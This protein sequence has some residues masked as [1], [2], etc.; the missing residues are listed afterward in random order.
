MLALSLVSRGNS[1][2]KSFR[3]LCGASICALAIGAAVPVFA[4]Q[5]P[6]AAAAAPAGA[7]PVRW[8]SS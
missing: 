3:M 1:Y 2:M 4:Q 6:A 5:A 8:P 7:K